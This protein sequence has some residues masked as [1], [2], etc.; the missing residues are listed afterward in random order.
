MGSI[1]PLSNCVFVGELSKESDGI[2]ISH[3]NTAEGE[4]M[5][6]TVCH[7][8]ISDVYTYQGSDIFY[9][10][11]GVGGKVAETKNIFAKW[12]ETSTP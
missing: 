5:G 1:I 4:E 3:L 8:D 7:A 2:K 12:A 6:G 11:N 9:W 10:I